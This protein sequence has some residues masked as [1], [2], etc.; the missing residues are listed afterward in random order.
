MNSISNHILKIDVASADTFQFHGPLTTGLQNLSF[1]LDVKTARNFHVE[2][3]HVVNGE[4][5]I[6]YKRDYERQFA[7]TVVNLEVPLNAGLNTINVTDL[8]PTGLRIPGQVIHPF[9]SKS[10]TD[11]VSSHP[12]IPIEVIQ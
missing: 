11:S 4:T 12:V 7:T 3:T 8:T 10:S 9:R 2:V 5:V 1:T 6:S